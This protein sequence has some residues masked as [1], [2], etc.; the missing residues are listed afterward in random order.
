M[1]GQLWRTDTSTF[2]DGGPRRELAAAAEGRAARTGEVAKK[3]PSP[4]P[5]Y[6]IRVRMLVSN[7]ATAFLTSRDTS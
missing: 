7:V 6:K 5:Q 2:S 4:R 3:P 1:I